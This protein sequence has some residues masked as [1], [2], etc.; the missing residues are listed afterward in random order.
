MSSVRDSA[1]VVITYV[2][3]QPDTE[4]TRPSAQDGEN[5]PVGKRKAPDWAAGE[6]LGPSAES[7]EKA[8]NPIIFSFL[9]AKSF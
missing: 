5:V 9:W 7:G 8:E 2:L 6:Q 4:T 1:A 3:L